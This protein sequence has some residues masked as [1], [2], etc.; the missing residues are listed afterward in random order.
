[1][2]LL[3]GFLCRYEFISTKNKA[4][5]R[6]FCFGGLTPFGFISFCLLKPFQWNRKL[7]WHGSCPF[8]RCLWGLFFLS[9]VLVK[10]CLLIFKN[11]ID[12]GEYIYPSSN[13][14]TR[15][16]VPFPGP[17]LCFMRFHNADIQKLC[18]NIS[19]LFYNLTNQLSY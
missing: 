1:M 5:F 2:C 4:V 3:C 9:D 19:M 16:S 7:T 10:P 17:S 14:E 13:T 12:I 15:H 11:V 6:C 18:E 8:N